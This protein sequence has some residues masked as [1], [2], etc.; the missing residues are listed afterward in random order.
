MLAG[1]TPREL[2]TSASARPSRVTRNA[3]IVFEPALT[4]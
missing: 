1:A 3:E 4:A 2:T